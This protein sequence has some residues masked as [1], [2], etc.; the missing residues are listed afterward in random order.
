MSSRLAVPLQKAGL[1]SINT[2]PALFGFREMTRLNV[3][4]FH[5]IVL[6]V[7]CLAET[8]LFGIYA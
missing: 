5:E 7:P 2:K 8:F 3:S 4:G 6:E 1:F